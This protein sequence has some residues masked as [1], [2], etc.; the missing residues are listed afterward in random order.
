MMY[1]IITHYNNFV[2]DDNKYIIYSLSNRMNRLVQI[3]QSIHKKLENFSEICHRF[4]R[5]TIQYTGIHMFVSVNPL[6][7]QDDTLSLTSQ[8]IFDLFNDRK[9]VVY[10]KQMSEFTFC[11]MFLNKEDA[12]ELSSFMNNKCIDVEDKNS[13]SISTEYIEPKIKTVTKRF[14]WNTKSN[15][16]FVCIPFIKHQYISVE[17]LVERSNE[18]RM[19]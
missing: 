7:C 4:V 9:T 17:A 1:D 19:S 8:D 5:N 6:N 2:S 14:D 13:Y 16:N 12:K 10:C 3:E 18:L 15:S 11:L